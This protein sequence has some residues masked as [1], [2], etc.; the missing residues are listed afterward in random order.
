[1]RKAFPLVILAILLAASTA[2]LSAQTA[3]SPDA[4]LDELIKR[5]ERF[6]EDTRFADSKQVLEEALEKSPGDARILWRLARD[7]Y[8]LA[9]I[10]PREAKDERLVLF[11]EA[12]GRTRRCLETSPDEGECHFWLG[13]SLGRIATT[14]GILSNITAPPREIAPSFNKAIELGL[15]YR[16]AK[17]HLE[18]ANAHYALGQFYRLTPDSWLV[19]K[20]IGVRGDLELSIEHLQKALELEPD[21]LEINKEMGISLIC[22]GSERKDSDM[23]EEGR[24]RLERTIA[25]PA[26]EPTDEVD[27]RH[28][29]MLLDDPDLCCSYSRDGQQERDVR[30]ARD[31]YKQSGGN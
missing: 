22:L 17:G 7:C 4:S 16:S 10:L 12:E 5:G 8:E 9:E 27:K 28:A 26:L 13:A 15:P 14:K 18:L 3:T 23:V 21:R 6:W 25:L 1:M 24:R 31:K 11:E 30:K 2:Q 29:Q 20:M 19:S